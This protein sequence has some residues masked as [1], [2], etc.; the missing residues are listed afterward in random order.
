MKK[1][2]FLLLLLSNQAFASM[3]DDNLCNQSQIC[4]EY[5]QLRKEDKFDDNNPKHEE[6]L[7]ECSQSLSGKADKIAGKMVNDVTQ[8]VKMVQTRC[9]EYYK[10]W[11]EDKIDKT[12]EYHNKLFNQC[13][14]VIS[15]PGQTTN[16]EEVNTTKK[17]LQNLNS[18]AAGSINNKN[19]KTAGNDA[20]DVTQIVKMAQI[21]CPEYCELWQEGKIDKTSEYHNK[22]FRQ[23]LRRMSPPSQITSKERLNTIKEILRNLDS[24]GISA[25]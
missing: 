11:Q 25:N 7:L 9:P 10:L 15:P 12:S 22:L 8:I 5:C 16:K 18:Y 1:I 14:K 2:L 24:Y 21:R 4:K 13:L 23:C 6:M 19:D 20:N 3:I 17:I